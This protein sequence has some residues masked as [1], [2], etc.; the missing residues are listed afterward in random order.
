MTALWLLLSVLTGQVETGLDRLAADQFAALKGKRVVFLTNHSAVDKNGVHLLRRIKDQQVFTLA[1]FMAP[2]HGFE[3]LLD[4]EGIED[5]KEAKTGLPIYSLYG[6][7]KRPT[8]EMLRDVDVLV[9]D[10]Q[11]IGTRFYTYQTT[12]LYAMEACAQAGVTVMVLDRPNPL[13]G[14]KVAGP[15]LDEDQRSF[16][17][18]FPMPIV[19]G[20]TM[21]ELARLFAA[22][23]EPAP[24]LEVVAMRGWR[25]SM[26]FSQ[27]G[28]VWINPSPNMRN[29]KQA[30]L[31]PAVGLLERTNL[32]VGR[33]TDAP[34]EQFGAPWLDA[35]AFCRAMNGQRLGGV[36]FVPRFFT[37]SSGPYAGERCGGVWI[38]LEDA[39]A[40]EPIRTGFALYRQLLG[41]SDYRGAPFARLLADR[42][43]Y[44][45][46]QGDT[47][48]DQ[49]LN[50]DAEA[51]AVFLEKRRSVLLYR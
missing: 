46:L 10:I 36:R 47:P 17:G 30:T 13:G 39:D 7:T 3:G 22:E 29:P 2:E 40:F 49:A 6:A 43:V 1:A 14:E 9:F 42:A 28:L 51:L 11:D 33:G 45:A 38:M 12:L 19:H 16:T 23:M 32:S 41:L 50:M 34:F 18:A 25:R 4:R 15:I 27:T 31:Y 5:S 26:D 44:D 37:P 8:P 35:V 21:G 48:L 20:M 24:R